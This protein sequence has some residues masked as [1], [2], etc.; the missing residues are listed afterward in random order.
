MTNATG[1]L[2][3]LTIGG[4][5]K[6]LRRARGL[7][8]GELSH[9]AGVDDSTLSRWENGKRQPLIPELEA[10]LKAL[11][12]DVATRRSILRL[13]D[14]PRS[15]AR[16]RDLDAAAAPPI[17]GDLL[18]ALRLR[19]GWTQEQ[20][21]CA[22][23]V[24]RTQVTRWER[25]DS[26]PSDEKLHSLC[27]YLGADCDELADLS[28]VS[29]GGQLHYGDTPGS[30]GD[31]PDFPREGQE[32]TPE[33]ALPWVSYVAQHLRMSPRSFVLKMFRLEHRLS[34]LASDH[35]LA[36]QLLP[37]AY[38][39]QARHHL[40][41]QEKGQAK[42]AAQHGLALMR[43]QRLSRGL[44]SAEFLWFG[45]VIVLASLAAQERSPSGL[46]RAIQLLTEWLPTVRG[47]LSHFTWGSADLA[48][49]LALQGKTDEAVR[50]GA[51]VC[52]QVARTLPG[53]QEYRLQDHAHVLCQ[54][55]RPREALQVLVTSRAVHDDSAGFFS[56]IRQ[57]LLEAQCLL[58]LQDSGSADERFRAAEQIVN[59]TGTDSRQTNFLKETARIQRAANH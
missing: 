17:G 47:C 48:Y 42:A 46:R 6:T 31:E 19:K 27:R 9:L 45:N 14:A 13:L 29:G 49:Y 11:E 43:R 26:W 33:A 44:G 54:V 24:H 21:A 36:E 7:T 16:L 8:L 23:G 41:H 32:G 53:E 59:Q 40:L 57:E 51:D 52:R 30:P 39:I 50:L 10:A 25:G 1:D 55:G 56:S 2:P 15:L 34:L 4:L 3:E 22:I 58:S 12:A 37:N 38:A 20:T 28:I 18:H 5:L 35:R